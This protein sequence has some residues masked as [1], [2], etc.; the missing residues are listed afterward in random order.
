MHYSES[1]K[2]RNEKWVSRLDIGSPHPMKKRSI[3]P[4]Y[5]R[6]FLRFVFDDKRESSA[7]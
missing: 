2:E 1:E 4:I 7:L 5:E 6:G 3:V